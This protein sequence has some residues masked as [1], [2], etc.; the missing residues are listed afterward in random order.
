MSQASEH[1]LVNHRVDA[2]LPGY[3]MVGSKVGAN[4]LHDLSA[5]LLAPLGPILATI[6]QEIERLLR[7]KRV[8]IGRNGIRRDIRSISL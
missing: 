1:W 7:P 6:Q 4:A 2:V 8:Y 5:D 3:L